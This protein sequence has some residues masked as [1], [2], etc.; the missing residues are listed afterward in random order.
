MKNKHIKKLYKSI[1]NF[2]KNRGKDTEREDRLLANLTKDPGWDILKHRL[3]RMM[4][5]LLEPLGPEAY[6][7][8]EMV[9]SIDFAKSFTLEAIRKIIATVET[10][11]AVLE[12]QKQEQVERDN[13]EENEK[14]G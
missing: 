11:N 14:K 3:E 5:E 10:T 13:P 7:N 2:E 6:P 1:D 4:T 8:V 12:S 9:A